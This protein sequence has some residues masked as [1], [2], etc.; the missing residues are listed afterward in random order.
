MKWDIEKSKE[1]KEKIANDIELMKELSERVEKVFQEFGLDF[2][3]MSYVFEP[4]VFS[5]EGEEFI[6]VSRKSLPALI[7][8]ILKYHSILDIHEIDISKYNCLPQCGPLDPYHLKIIERLRIREIVVDEPI[9]NSA[10]LMR[11]IMGDSTLHQKLS[12]A[13]FEPL[14]ERGYLTK[15]EGCVFTPMVFP[16]PV[17][18]Q[19]VAK[20]NHPDEITGFAPQLYDFSDINSTSALKF[21]PLAGIIEIEKATTLIPGVII[22][23]LWWWIGIPAPEFLRALDRLKDIAHSKEMEQLSK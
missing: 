21:K 18:A 5:M 20:I 9:K 6:E 7:S 14:I 8:E 17:F 3:E 11:R 1:L 22:D 2:K 15:D 10:Q 19:K 12:E 13:L 16:A 4:R 23:K